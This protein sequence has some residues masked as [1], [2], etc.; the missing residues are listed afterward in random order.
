RPSMST[1]AHIEKV[2]ELVLQNLR[3]TVQEIAD[4]VGI[5]FGS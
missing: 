3:L 2:K 1:D 5:S 4:E